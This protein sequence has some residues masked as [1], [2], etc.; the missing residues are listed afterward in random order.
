MGVSVIDASKARTP[1]EKEKVIADVLSSLSGIPPEAADEVRAKVARMLENPRQA[2]EENLRLVA[3]RLA[4]FSERADL[5]QKQ[6]RD[7]AT[8]YEDGQTIHMFGQW[9]GMMTI[10]MGTMD[11]VASGLTRFLDGEDDATAET[12]PPPAP[13][14]EPPQ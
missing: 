11:V 9:D 10:A 3:R 12:E 7:A 4:G 2:V 1:E 6:L 14:A 8:T 13:E 5:L